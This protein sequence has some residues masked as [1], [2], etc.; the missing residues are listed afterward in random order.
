MRRFAYTL[1]LAA[2]IPFVTTE[3]FATATSSPTLVVPEGARSGDSVT[4]TGTSPSGRGGTTIRVG[5]DDSGL[6]T[7][8]TWEG[9][10]FTITFKA[11]P[12]NPENPG[13]EIWIKV[14][15]T[16]PNRTVEEYIAVSP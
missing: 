13:N 5:D 6:K 10:N 2:I 8:V 15:P 9:N 7:E 3:G 12:F 16:S 14:R 4:V 1:M 11:P